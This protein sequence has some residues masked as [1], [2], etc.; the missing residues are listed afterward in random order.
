M[1]NI[2]ISLKAV[3]TTIEVSKIEWD[4]NTQVVFNISD[5][6]PLIPCKVAQINQAIHSLLANASE[7]I[8]KSE[9]SQN[10]LISVDISTNQSVVS[11]HITDNG[12]GIPKKYRDRIFES[13]FSTKGTGKGSGQGLALCHSIITRT[14]GGTLSFKT[15]EGEGTTFTITLPVSK[16]ETS[17]DLEAKAISS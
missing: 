15:K 7:A 6:I 17:P 4:L 3:K 1:M 2:S 16:Q 8:S 11:I 5:N 9:N 10:G 12:N 14:H 13:A